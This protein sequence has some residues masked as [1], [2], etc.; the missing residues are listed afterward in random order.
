[1]NAAWPFLTEESNSSTILCRLKSDGQIGLLDASQTILDS[2]H[3]RPLSLFIDGP[4]L[5]AQSPAEGIPCEER[6]VSQVAMPKAGWMLHPLG[7]AAVSAVTQPSRMITFAGR[8]SSSAVNKEAIFEPRFP[9]RD[10]LHKI[11]Q[12]G[13]ESNHCSNCSA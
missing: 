5:Q 7:A 9:V 12:G 3:Q 6:I 13:A 10:G 2:S 8:L 1:M 11:G 4:V